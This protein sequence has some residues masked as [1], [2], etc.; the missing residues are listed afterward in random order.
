MLTGVVRRFVPVH[1]SVVRNR[2]KNAKKETLPGEGSREA[3][4]LTESA[5][6]REQD[7]ER[8]GADHLS[9]TLGWYV[10]TRYVL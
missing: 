1:E 9:Y 8:S 10:G 2:I 5:A 6:G 7:R 4:S 3:A